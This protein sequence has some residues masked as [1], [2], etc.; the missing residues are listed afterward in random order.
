MRPPLSVY[1]RAL[2]ASVV[3]TPVAKRKAA[4]VTPRGFLESTEKTN[5]FDADPVA[6][7]VPRTG[8]VTTGVIL[9]FV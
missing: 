1:L 4:Q 5:Y 7:I 8:T 9:S 3:R 6:L 2:C